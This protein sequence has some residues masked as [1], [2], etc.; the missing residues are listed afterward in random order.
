MDPKSFGM[1]AADILEQSI[2][3]SQGMSFPEPPMTPQPTTP[4]V[5][6]GTQTPPMEPFSS[7]LSQPPMPQAPSVP[8]ALYEPPPVDYMQPE[9]P[10]AFMTLENPAPPPMLPLD[11]GVASPGPLRRDNQFNPNMN[12]Y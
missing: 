10:P 4:Q 8:P 5:Q 2:G 12:P 1:L 7:T 9:Q 3:Q 6:A 11:E